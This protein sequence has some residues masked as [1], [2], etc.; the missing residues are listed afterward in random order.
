VYL[1]LGIQSVQS[2]PVFSFNG[3]ALGTFVVAFNEP[4]ASSSFDV[5]LMAFGAHGMR[6]ILQKSSGHNAGPRGVPA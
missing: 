3:K 5:E 2:A 6:I 1:D 4:K